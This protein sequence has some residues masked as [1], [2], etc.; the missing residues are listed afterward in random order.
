VSLVLVVQRR[1]AASP[2][3]LFRAW[4]DPTELARWWGPKGVRCSHTEIDLVVGGSYVIDNVLPTGAVIRITGKFLEIDPPEK[5]AFSWAVDDREHSIVTVRFRAAGDATDVVV[6]H[7]RIADAETRASHEAGWNG[8]L[9]GL[10]R[11]IAT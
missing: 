10:A 3:R 8:C 1:I 2:A 4:T 9:D 6:T 5:L 7:E 11:M